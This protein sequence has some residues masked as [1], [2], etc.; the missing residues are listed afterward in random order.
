MVSPVRI[1]IVTPAFNVAPYL[2]ETI[3]SILDQTHQDWSMV[4]V[5]DGSTDDTARVVR[6]FSDP[7]LRLISQP[8]AGVSA[9]RNRG[10]EALD[11]S[12]I[13]FLD[14]DDWLAP[15][16]LTALAEALGDVPEAVAAVGAY[17]RGGC[18]YRPVSGDLLKR[19]LVRNLFVNGGH[20]L[21]RR[22]H[23]QPFRHD[24][25]Y[26]EDW[27]CW[28]RLACST[29]VPAD[30]QAVGGPSPAMTLELGPIQ[31]F[32][33]ALFAP[34][35]ETRPILF[36][37]ERPGGAYLSMATNPTSFPPCLDAI[38]GNPA[39]AARFPPDK[40]AA[41]R[42]QAEA[43]SQ[44]VIGRELIR[45]RRHRDGLRWLGRSVAAAPSVRRAAL[46]ALAAG[47]PML[48]AA[49]RGPLRPYASGTVQASYP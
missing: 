36:V 4:V 9:A 32:Q 25:R 14:G 11:C 17:Q 15:F 30:A 26:G 47:L 43:E 46:L 28:V 42:L 31:Y 13:L 49:W 2:G 21:I 6:G 24:L 33:P 45:H 38:H 37:R 22:D 23:V 44:W 20:V 40:R 18:V 1:G 39:L 7:R 5:D 27:E 41:L 12:A 19:L 34:T 3:R 29:P 8:N 35:L 48:P 10:A 16:A